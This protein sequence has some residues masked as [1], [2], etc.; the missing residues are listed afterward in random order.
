MPLFRD[1][2]AG[3]RMLEAGCFALLP[4]VGHSERHEHERCGRPELPYK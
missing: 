2:K 1:K 4:L 3:A